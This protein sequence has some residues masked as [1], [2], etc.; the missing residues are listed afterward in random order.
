M[1]L[2][3]NLIDSVAKS[4]NE[5]IVNKKYTDKVLERLFK[6]N[7]QWGSRDRRFVAEVTYD[8][9]RNYR[10][11]YSIIESEKNFWLQIAVWLV[12]K[13][14]ELPQWQEF[15][16][17][18]PNFI[19]KKEQL[20]SNNPAIKQSYPDWLWELASTELGDDVWLKESS[21]MN[22]QAKVVLRC[23]T[24]KININDLQKKLNA[25]GIETTKVNDVKDALIL[26]KRQNI[27]TNEFFKQGFFEVQDAGSQEISNFFDLAQ[28]EI[29]IDACAGAGGK[30]LHLAAR[31]NNKSKIISMDVEEWK[32]D[33]LKKRSKRAGAFNI[34][35]IHIKNNETINNL[36]G[37]ATK[38]LLDVPCSGIGVIKRN[39]D[40]KWKLTQQSILD[41]IAL[42]KNILNDY[43]KMLKPNGELLYSTC[44]IFPS[45]NKNQV[46]EFLKTN[47]E[48]K[49][50]KE[51]SVMPSQGFDGFYMCLLKKTN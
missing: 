25:I 5:I 1:K 21:S 15:V 30:T 36:K 35:T 9:V 50:I 3:K 23:N 14:I 44:S 12:L 28:N 47:P 26:N 13:N 42:Q 38:L 18:D 17:I 37:K 48:F 29:I 27:F 20:L 33:E 43:S 31:L 16:H 8:C 4:L 40:A 49:I 41:T 10:L 6:Q 24:L 34:E 51:K 7:P 46:N 45:E 39:P 22:E 19:K 32:L 11:H 2:Y